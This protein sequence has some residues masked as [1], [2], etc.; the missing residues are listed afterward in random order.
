MRQ[1]TG[2]VLL[3]AICLGFTACMQ[4]GL[5]KDKVL[6]D[7]TTV[8][9][10]KSDFGKIGEKDVLWDNL[11]LQSVNVDNEETVMPL[12]HCGRVLSIGATHTTSGC[13]NQGAIDIG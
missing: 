10:M 12:L 7:V 11:P 6:K 9:V 1:I 13:P 2:S 3:L 5:G 4:Q 8:S